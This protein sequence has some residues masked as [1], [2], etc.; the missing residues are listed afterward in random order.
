MSLLP[1]LM[2]SFQL[3]FLIC[4]ALAVRYSGKPDRQINIVNE[5]GV[6]IQIHWINPDTDELILQSDPFMHIGASFPLNSFVGHEFQVTELPGKGG[7]CKGDSEPTTTTPECLVNY[8]AVN[9]NHE[10]ILFVRKH[11]RIDHVD[12]QSKAIENSS[13]SIQS[14]REKALQQISSTDAAAIV[15]SLV[16]CIESSVE[17]LLI[18]ANDEI[19]FQA[20]I[21]SKLADH[22]ENYTCYDEN[23]NT[24]EPI[25]SA[26]W[27]DKGSIKTVD[28][29]HMHPS[30][31]IHLVHDFV[32]Q[33]ECAAV[34]A[35]A[36][37]R[38][39]RATVADGKGGS[40]YSP[41]RKALQA[42]ISIPWRLEAEGNLLARLSRRVY[43]YTNHV[44]DLNIKEDG[45]EDLM[46]IQYFGTN[47]VDG[48]PDRY[49][50]HCDGD[51]D[52]LAFKPGNRMAT[53]VRYDEQSMYISDLVR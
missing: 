39:H 11:L 33:E 53:M 8:F 31:Q 1:I 48:P 49:M 9:E 51:C 5:S 38:L 26:T 43:D 44:L 16:E 15:D 4:P 13:Y 37:P 23:L 25:E 45:Q 34:E 50:P 42:G 2:R 40:E 21:R 20:D 28:I 52:G 19:A 46:S 41:N 6:K 12:N 17:A 27:N 3:A 47:S 14:C 10:Q 35:A 22:F 32:S 24:T 36:K 29:L 30:S 18:D 7:V